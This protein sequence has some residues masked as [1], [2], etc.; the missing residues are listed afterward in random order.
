[1]VARCVVECSG[2]RC[3]AGGLGAQVLELE[4][5]GRQV[6][7]CIKQLTNSHKLSCDSCKISEAL[8]SQQPQISTVCVNDH[9]AYTLVA[10]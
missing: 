10:A 2:R 9:L 4:G 5:E 8:D 6:C 7:N 3:R 1:M